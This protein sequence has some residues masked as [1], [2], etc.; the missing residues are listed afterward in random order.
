M[1]LW[2]RLCVCLIC[3]SSVLPASAQMR[4]R[5]TAVGK[6]AGTDVKAS[7]EAKM[8]AKR[9]AIEQ[10]C[11]LF[12]NAQSETE[13]FVL[14]KD[15]ILGQAGG[16][17]SEFKVNREWTEG[18]ISL[19]EIDAVVSTADFERDWAK[20]AQLKEEEENPKM[21]VVIVEDNDVDDLKPPITNGVCQAK[22]ENFFLGKD[23]QLVDKGV[24]E[25]VR[26]RDITL[27]AMNND[28]TRLAALAAE[29]KAEVL[30]FGRA[31]AR[32]GSPL[33]IGGRTTYRW[34]ITLNVRA[35]QADS[36]AML[37]SNSYAPNKPHMT[38]SAAAGD[39]AFN[40]LTDDVAVNVL[41]DIGEA[42]RKRATA[43]RILQT[44]FSP[45]SRKQAKAIMSALAQH[46]G[47]VRGE[48]GLKLR[49]L[50]QGI[51]NIEID[52]KFDL[53]LLADTIEELNVEGM[54]FEITEQSSNRIDVKVITTEPRP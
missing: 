49:N 36:A 35:I 42:W 26:G 39:D 46:R 14:V 52:W 9:N 54:A 20:F 16:Y 1:R 22:I 34:D 37:M 51:A 27:A 4:R 45:V 12:I 53:N 21:L 50:S 43:R 40:R 48:E 19:C 17:I 5:V 38:T 2:T 15:R 11:G 25:D 30:V 23:V 44:R 28:V 13:D 41:K 10:A 3:L 32:R 31:E 33:S 7:D 29:F 47:V 8:D 24:S 6:A 18:D